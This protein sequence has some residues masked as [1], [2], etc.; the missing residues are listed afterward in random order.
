V[1][2]DTESD[3]IILQEMIGF[4]RSMWVMTVDA[5]FLHRIML[6]FHLD[7]GI[8][9]ILMTVK[10][11]FIA[12]LK[13]N[14]LIIRCMGVVAFNTIAIHHNFMTAFGILG[15]NSFMALIAYFVRI[16]VE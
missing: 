15:H 10:T 9:N 14:K 2:A 3:Q 4:G 13:E 11:E 5:S 8:P 16:F 12:C 1:T 7:N 6:E